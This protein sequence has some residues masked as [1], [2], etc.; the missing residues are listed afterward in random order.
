[1]SILTKLYRF[2]NGAMARKYCL[3]TR[4]E[5]YDMIYNSTLEDTCKIGLK[6]HTGLT[7]NNNRVYLLMLV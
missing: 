1:M 3:Q 4:E 6:F 7:S 2:V 5:R